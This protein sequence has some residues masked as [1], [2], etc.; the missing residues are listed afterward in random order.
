MTRRVA[1]WAAACVAGTATCLCAGLVSVAA[2]FRFGDDPQ[3]DLD[4]ERDAR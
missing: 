4:D 2:A 1:C 3:P